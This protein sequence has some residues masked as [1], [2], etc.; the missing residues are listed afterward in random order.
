MVQ[1]HIGVSTPRAEA[2]RKAGK[3]IPPSIPVMGLVDTGA[4]CTAIDAGILSQ[5]AIPSSGTSPTH[6]PSTLAGVPHVANLFDVSVTLMHSQI[7]K[8]FHALPVL[9]SH[10]AHQG[11]HVLIGRDIL[12]NCLLVYDGVAQSFCLSF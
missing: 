11:F 9:E 6:T 10:L 1:I 3:P 8:R 5:L 4:S 12:S 2:L 7:G